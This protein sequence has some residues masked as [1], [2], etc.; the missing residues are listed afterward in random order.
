MTKRNNRGQSLIEV[1]LSIGVIVLVVTGVIVLIINTVSIKTEAFQRK[2]ASEMAATVV[3]KLL[4][5]KKN[6]GDSFWNLS[7][8]PS[9]TLSGFDGF[10]YGVGFSRITDGNCSDDINSP[11][12][13]NAT[14]TIF[15]G[16]GKSLIVNR[17]FSK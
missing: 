2:K 16:N 9:T 5:D 8:I 6:S 17:F 15:W 4:E 11:D 14:V 3:E 1:V 13:A 10:N 7:V 12:C